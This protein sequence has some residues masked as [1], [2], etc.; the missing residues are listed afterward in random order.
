MDRADRRPGQLLQP[1]QHHAISQRE[2]FQDATHRRPGGGTQNRLLCQMAADAC[3]CRVV[4]G[5][6]EATAIGNVMMQ[7]V[8]AGDL[9][10]IAEAREVIRHSFEA[11]E[12]APQNPAGWDEAYARFEQLA[13][14]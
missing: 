9:G 6:V 3:N 14:R 5:P 12:Y 10:S 13:D 8:S 11:E 4:A 2:A 1:A 7:A